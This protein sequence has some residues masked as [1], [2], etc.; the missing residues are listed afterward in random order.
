MLLESSFYP[1][2]PPILTLRIDLSCIWSALEVRDPFPLNPWAKGVNHQNHPELIS[3]VTW[4]SSSCFQECQGTVVV[5]HIQ[6]DYPRLGT[7]VDY[8]F[9]PELLDAD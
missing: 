3:E 6:G 7:E 8:Q 4:P 2:K 1:E 9:H 5:G